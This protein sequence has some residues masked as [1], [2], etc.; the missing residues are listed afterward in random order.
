MSFK[1]SKSD[2]IFVKEL[3][4][5]RLATTTM[6]CEPMVRPVWPVFDGKNVYIATDAGLPKIKQIENNPKVCVVF[7]D[8]DKNHWETLRGVRMQGNAVIL[9]EGEEYK[10]AH[11]LLMD[12]YPEYRPPSELSWKDDEKVPIIK[13][14]PKSVH[15]WAGGDWAK[16]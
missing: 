5:C 11:K 4:V 8:Y 10:Y 15:R 9:W 14:A 1:L 16:Q 3:P 7:D 12:K 13:V 6:N 2:A